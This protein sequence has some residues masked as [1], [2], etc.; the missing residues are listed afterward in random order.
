MLVCI[1]A[2]R[3]TG[4]REIKSHL[5]L[6]KMEGKRNMRKFVVYA[7]VLLKEDAHKKKFFFN[8]RAT[9]REGGVKPPD[10]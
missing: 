8:G 7:Y 10:H 5:K 4:T 1:Y 2:V 3:Y 9:K 6:R